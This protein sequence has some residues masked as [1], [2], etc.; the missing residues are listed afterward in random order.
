MRLRNSATG[1][2]VVT[3]LLHWLTAMLILGL[4]GLGWYMV[5]LTYFDRWY[6]ESLS[7]H[8]ALGMIV[9]GLG[10]L[11]L[12]WRA[13]SPSP[14]SI[15]SHRPWEKTVGK[16]VHRTLFVGV[17]LLPLSGYLVSTSAGKAVSVFGLID[18]PA[19]MTISSD[20]R[21][22]AISIHFYLGYG[23]AVL[24]GLH[25]SAAIKHQLIDR[26]GTLARMLWR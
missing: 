25:A 6:N 3:K 17:L 5:D 10:L 7:W 22:I 24:A 16:L 9:L 11:T 14:A 23:I 20:A 1:Y 21:D 26:D 18:I 15:E 13:V 12:L 4:V 19:I 8:K 2:G